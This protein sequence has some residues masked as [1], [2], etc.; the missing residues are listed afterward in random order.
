M[1]ED[2]NLLHIRMVW[3]I[4]DRYRSPYEH[5]EFYIAGP[6]NNRLY[7]K[8]GKIWEFKWPIDDSYKRTASALTYFVW[9][10][11]KT[12]GDKRDLFIMTFGA[13]TMSEINARF[14]REGATL[15]R[16]WKSEPSYVAPLPPTVEH[17]GGCFIATAAYGSSGHPDVVLLRTFRDQILAKSL[18]GRAFS[19]FYYYISPTLV[20]CIRGKV[21][22]SAV[23]C[24]VIVPTLRLVKRKMRT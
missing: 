19:R 17:T 10:H 13:M 22:R 4:W 24:L 20:L 18:L 23:K 8:G 9:N 1:S 16:A 12:E 5:T 14:E 11:R 3:A 6:Y 2:E 21:A 7:H 15:R